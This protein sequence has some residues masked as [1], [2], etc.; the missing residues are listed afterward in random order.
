VAV[1]AAKSEL[2]I[3]EIESQLGWTTELPGSTLCYELAEDFAEL[4]RD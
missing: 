1:A 2:F 3:K 4:Y